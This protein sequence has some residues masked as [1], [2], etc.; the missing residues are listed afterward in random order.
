M[1]RLLGILLL[2][3]MPLLSVAQ[4]WSLLRPGWK[5]NY[6][7]T[8]TGVVDSQIFITASDTPNVGVVT[9]ELNRIANWCDTCSEHIQPDLPQFLQRSVTVSND[10]WNFHDPASIVILPLDTL[11]STWIMDTLANVIAEVTAVDTLIQFDVP[12]VQKTI[13]CSNGDFWVISQ[14][15]GIILVNDLELRGI[16]GPDV[17]ALVP[18]VAQMYPYQPGDIMEIVKSAHGFTTNG[19]FPA[20]SFGSHA[21]YTILERTD[22]NDSVW[23]NTWAL[24]ESYVS[25]P[26]GSA[27]FYTWQSN[28]SDTVP[29]STSAIELPQRDLMFSYPGELITSEHQIYGDSPH[30]ECIARHRI[31]SLGRYCMECDLDVCGGPDFVSYVEGIGLESYGWQCVAKEHYVMFGTVINGD[32]T[33]TI[34]PDSNFVSVPE[35]ALLKIKVYPNPAHD[36]LVVEGLDPSGSLLMVMDIQGRIMLQENVHAPA[37][38]LDVSMLTAGIYTLLVRGVSP[39]IPVKLVIAR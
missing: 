16:Q 32:T 13:T 28:W 9:H 29:W 19:S 30:F 7:A 11:G 18:T 36:L 27:Q 25:L 31:D 14:E 1:A 2:L 23:F 33:G 17:G 39:S 21:K 22:E 4:Q 35:H 26:A 37:A 38:T 24:Y 3:G 15:W 12:D 5:Y 20:G 34:S 8:N 6:S 10:V